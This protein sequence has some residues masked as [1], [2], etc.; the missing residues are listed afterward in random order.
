MLTS[1]V[2]KWKLRQADRIA[3]PLVL[4]LHDCIENLRDEKGKLSDE[5]KD[6]E[7]VLT[8]IYGM[9]TGRLERVG[10]EKDALVAAL[11]LRQTFE[12]LFGEGQRRAELCAGLAKCH[13]GDFQY[14]AKLGYSDVQRYALGWEIPVGLI[15][16]LRAYD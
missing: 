13:D 1:L 5:I 15:N 9:V 8:Y 7:F 14:A 11:A 12:Y 6:D 3:K 16:H 10:K 4:T 2:L